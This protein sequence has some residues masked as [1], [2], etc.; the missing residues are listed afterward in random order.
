[1]G[2][3]LALL[4]AQRH[5]GRVA[6]V[7]I[8]NG[9]GLRGDGSEARVSLLPRTREEARAAM[10]A[11]TS[12]ASGA[13]PN[14]ILD[15]LVRRAPR[16]PLARIMAV[17]FAELLLDGKRVRMPQEQRSERSRGQILDAALRLFSRQGYRGTSMREIALA[18]KLSTGNV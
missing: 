13:V 1:M 6:R 5:P 2:G 16:S 9:A 17:P 14:F 10:E 7:V 4:Y 3:W 12:P 18:A 11:V 15:D 8:V